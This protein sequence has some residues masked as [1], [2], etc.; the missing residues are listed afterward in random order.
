MKYAEGAV[1]V[2]P[3]GPPQG[4]L[5]WGEITTAGLSPGDWGHSGAVHI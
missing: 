5:P 3:L 4:S 2:Q 1:R